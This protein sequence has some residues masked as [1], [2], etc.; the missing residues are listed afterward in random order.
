MSVS[1]PTALRS[2]PGPFCRRAAAAAVAAAAAAAGDH[3][4]PMTRRSVRICLPHCP[5]RRGQ[6]R[7][8]RQRRPPQQQPRPPS[9][10]SSRWS[11]SGPICRSSSRFRRS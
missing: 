3:R 11:R 5:H 8:R 1:R 4:W 2:R 7:R 9:V 10:S 6:P